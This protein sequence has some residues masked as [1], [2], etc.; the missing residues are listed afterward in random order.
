MGRQA[1]RLVIVWWGFWGGG[2]GVVFVFGGL[3]VGGVGVGGVGVGV[4]VLWGVGGGGGGVGWGG[5]GGFVSVLGCAC[6]GVGG[7]GGWGNFVGVGGGVVCVGGGCGALQTTFGAPTR[8]L[9]CSWMGRPREKDY[10]IGENPGDGEFPQRGRIHS[11][12]SRLEQGER[13]LGCSFTFE[14]PE[15]RTKTS[16]RGTR[17]ERGL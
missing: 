10:F 3:G 15:K 5:G 8:F 6:E 17:R 4:G 11:L 2:G 7:W 12:V 13:K 1:T 9:P 16:G 14:F